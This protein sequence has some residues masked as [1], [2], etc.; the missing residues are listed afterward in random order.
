MKKEIDKGFFFCLSG[1]KSVGR[2]N[3]LKRLRFPSFYRDAN[4][5]LHTMNYDAQWGQIHSKVAFELS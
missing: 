5:R 4:Q 3:F 1:E 2:K